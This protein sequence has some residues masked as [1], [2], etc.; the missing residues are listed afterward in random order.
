M[1]RLLLQALEAAGNRVEL[2]SRFRSWQPVPDALR[3]TRLG[4]L[5]RRLSDRLV[6][7]LRM[8]PPEER[9]ELWF[10]Y[11]LYYKAPDWLGPRVS[12]ALGIPYVVAEASHASKR[13]SGP[14]SVGHE[15][16]AGAIRRAN[17]V[18][19]LNPA[20]R[21]CLLPLLGERRRLVSLKPFLG[22][23]IRSATPT[24]AEKLEIRRDL[25]DRFGLDTRT[26]WLLC[27]AM[28]RS[29]DKR[30]SYRILSQCL[31]RLRAL[32]WQLLV[33][34]DGPAR[35]EV[36]HALAAG[37]GN[38][39]RV[40]YAGA[41]NESALPAFYLAADLFVWP[42]VNEA[43]GM[44]ILEAQAHGLPVVAGRSGGVPHIVREGETGLLAPPDNPAGLSH[45]IA[46]LLAD[47]ERR[48]AVGA[49]ARRDYAAEH[50]FAR[51]VATLDSAL[52]GLFQRQ[53]A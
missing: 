43:Y 27:V 52:T 35:A 51:G 25:A 1:A 10:T 28:M 12:G 41:Q 16:A 20:D 46:E 49:A 2:A 42:A 19:D 34:G 9:P 47:P 44:A 17:L 30:A 11:H 6:R 38:G 18:L 39:S 33:V 26:P 31:E 22:P 40:I 5:G 53:S 29:G 24:K 4:D 15:A 50:S 37:A 48:A 36:M 45:A 14:W 13:A 32:P 7:R 3:Q 21:A 8:R 23:E